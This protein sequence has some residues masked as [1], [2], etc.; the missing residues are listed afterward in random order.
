MS[1]VRG[2][3]RG[4]GRDYTKLWLGNATSNL[5]DGVMFVAAPLLAS[6]LTENPLLVAG[7]SVAYTLPR[8][9]TSMVTGV[10]V[11]RADRRMLMVSVNAARA[12]LTALLGCGVLFGFASLWF[13]YAVF[14]GLG[15]LETAADNSA[16][17]LLPSVVADEQLDRANARIVS[18]QL[19]ADEFVGPP[20]GD[21]CLGWRRHCRS[22]STRPRSPGPR[23]VS[24]C[25]EDAFASTP[26]AGRRG[27]QSG[28]TWLLACDGC[29]AIR[30]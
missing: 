17:A 10:L 23:S 12:V 15:V 3:D 24:F 20:L 29:A 7:V 28:G 27:R 22:C 9:F 25:C 8:I 16:F 2:S 21:S 5:G 19:V 26:S 1:S 18:A 11:D 6:M 30:C 4:L 14:V 13:L